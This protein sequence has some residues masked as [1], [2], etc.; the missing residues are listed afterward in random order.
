MYWTEITY[1][2]KEKKILTNVRNVKIA[3]LEKINHQHV[4]KFLLLKWIM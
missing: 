2:S 3:N 4:L 1:S